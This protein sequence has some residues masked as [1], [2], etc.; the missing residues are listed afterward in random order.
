[1][2]SGGAAVDDR[3]S[4]TVSS[5]K[6]ESILKA[7]EILQKDMGITSATVERP[8]FNVKRTVILKLAFLI[9]YIA[10]LLSSHF[11]YVKSGFKWAVLIGIAFVVMIMLV[12]LK[13][14]IVGWILLY[15]RFAPQRLRASCRFEPSCS[16]Y[17]L[18]AIEKYGVFK[19]IFK[20]I[21]RLTRCHYPNGGVDYP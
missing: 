16:Q 9:I 15:Q 7:L 14:S 1:M 13:L 2:N 18:L 17:M 8:Q 10:L 3:Y 12:K 20:G 11:I 21:K 19:G 5:S 6:E 4:Q